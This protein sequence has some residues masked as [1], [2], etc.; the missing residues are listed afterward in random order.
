MCSLPRTDEVIGFIWVWGWRGEHHLDVSWLLRWS[1]LSPQSRISLDPCPKGL[2]QKGDERQDRKD[3]KAFGWSHENGICEHEDRAMKSCGQAENSEQVS[4][5]SALSSS[6]LQSSHFL[7][8]GP[9]FPHPGLAPDWATR[10]P[11]HLVKLYSGCF[12]EGVFGWG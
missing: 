6:P 12:C 5:R 7:I 8:A 2:L 1:K 11:G 4:E 9:L 3:E 10:V